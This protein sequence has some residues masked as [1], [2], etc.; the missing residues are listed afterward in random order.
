MNPDEISWLD[1]IGI[2]SVGLAVG[3]ILRAMM[4]WKMKLKEF[5]K[6]WKK[7]QREIEQIIEKSNN[8]QRELYK[9]L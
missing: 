8:K 9:I 7:T 4:G 3:Y 6:L 2:F 1:I 5:E